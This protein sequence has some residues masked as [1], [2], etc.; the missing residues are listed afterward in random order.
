[1]ISILLLTG[2]YLFVTFEQT[3]IT[4]VLPQE[5]EVFVPAENPGRLP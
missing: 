3:A 4:T 5:T 2:L 1:V